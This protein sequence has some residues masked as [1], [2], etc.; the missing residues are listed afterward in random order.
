MHAG[1]RNPGLSRRAHRAPRH[2]SHLVAA[3]PFAPDWIFRPDVATTRHLRAHGRSWRSRSNFGTQNQLHLHDEFATSSASSSAT[4][5]RA[6]RR[7]SRRRPS[8]PRRSC[9]LVVDHALH[10]LGLVQ[11]PGAGCRHGLC[12]GGRRGRRC[13]CGLVAAAGT[14]SSRLSRN[15]QGRA[16]AC[17][18]PAGFGYSRAATTA[19]TSEDGMNESARWRLDGQVALV[20]GP[21]RASAQPWCP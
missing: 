1:A 8:R 6:A 12:G 9:P 4:R 5:Y 15:G 14:R 18:I 21:A 16:G 13:R 7:R 11:R 2:R 20:T 3:M 10:R 19:A 17:G